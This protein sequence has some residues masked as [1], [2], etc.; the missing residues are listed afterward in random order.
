MAGF[1]VTGRG[2][3]HRIKQDSDKGDIKM[4]NSNNSFNAKNKNGDPY[5]ESRNIGSNNAGFNN[6]ES[7]ARS[8]RNEKSAGYGQDGT[9][10]GSGRAYVRSEERQRQLKE[11]QRR[12]A[13]YKG[14]S[15]R[16]LLAELE[17]LKA[18]DGGR[19]LTPQAMRDFRAKISPALSEEQK[20]KLDALL[21][22]LN[23]S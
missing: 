16:E 1:C 20:R 15:S 19:T 18:A 7:N 3:M 21:E 5:G 23:K 11:L 12:C 2:L 8:S 14:K 22:R 13:H 9:Y 17:R 4:Y 10:S 6:S